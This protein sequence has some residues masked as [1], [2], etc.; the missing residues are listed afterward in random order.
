M[1]CIIAYLLN[2]RQ[3][4]AQNIWRIFE[5]YA[6][7]WLIYE[8]YTEGIKIWLFLGSKLKHDWCKG[9]RSFDTGVH[10]SKNQTFATNIWKS[11]EISDISYIYEI[12]IT[13]IRHFCIKWYTGNIWYEI[14]SMSFAFGKFKMYLKCVVVTLIKCPSLQVWNV[15]SHLR[16]IHQM[17]KIFLGPQGLLRVSS[18]KWIG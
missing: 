6:H 4:L 15:W 14:Y 3:I 11:S 16:L 7:L 13:G 10:S 5:F 9:W 2:S 1:G 17:S 8:I 12:Y 18:V